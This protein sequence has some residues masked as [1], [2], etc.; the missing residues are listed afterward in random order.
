MPLL[1]EL[2]ELDELEEELLELELASFPPA[3]PAPPV[4]VSP[5]SEHPELTK[6][7]A[8]AMTNGMA[9]FTYRPEKLSNTPNLQLV[10][11]QAQNKL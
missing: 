2:D 6:A 1:D 10:T 11:F 7:A 9:I 8:A 5:P 3:P 4:F